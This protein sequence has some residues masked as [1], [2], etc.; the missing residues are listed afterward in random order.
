MGT[1]RPSLVRVAMA[2]AHSQC[3]LKC[4]SPARAPRVVGMVCSRGECPP[5]VHTRYRSVNP[6][7]LHDLTATLNP[8][9]PKCLLDVMLRSVD[10]YHIAQPIPEIEDLD[11]SEAADLCILDYS[12]TIHP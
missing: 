6:A 10:S 5:Y 8:V 9:F 12:K 3:D 1:T 11:S 7:I 2:A 4:G